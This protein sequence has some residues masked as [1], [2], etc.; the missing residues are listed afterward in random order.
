MRGIYR[1]S[2]LIFPNHQKLT[3]A[4]ISVIFAAIRNN[5]S[6]AAIENSITLAMMEAMD[7]SQLSFTSQQIC[8][9]AVY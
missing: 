8:D 9:E 6:R 5:R 3:K 7:L 2:L 4:R 1:R